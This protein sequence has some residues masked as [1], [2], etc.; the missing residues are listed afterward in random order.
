MLKRFSF[1]LFFVS[2]FV[3]LSQTSPGLAVIAQ[4]NKENIQLRWAPSDVNLWQA[5]ITHGYRVERIT[6]QKYK[7]SNIDSSRFRNAT[8]VRSGLVPWKKEDE[9]WKVL[10]AKNK[11]AAF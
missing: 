10:I 11:S 4:V 7:E 2:A 9:R 6:L 8:V 3:M 1:I 5:G